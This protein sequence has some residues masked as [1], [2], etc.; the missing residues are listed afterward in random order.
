M[1]IALAPLS[2]SDSFRQSSNPTMLP[3]AMP[4]FLMPTYTDLAP[5]SSVCD[6]SRRLGDS[7]IS[8]TR[9]DIA[10]CI[11][12]S[13]QWWILWATA[14]PIIVCIVARDILT[15]EATLCQI[16]LRGTYL[17]SLCS[18]NRIRLRVGTR[19]KVKDMNLF[20]SEAQL[21]SVKGTKCF[22]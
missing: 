16:W 22:P 21:V 11:P 8:T 14:P 20:L 18:G 1:P 19:L 10:M 4:S 2:A 17:R 6:S 13:S 7:P 5:I 9:W 15:G 12:S 3:P